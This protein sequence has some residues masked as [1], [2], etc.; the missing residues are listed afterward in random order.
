LT[1]K[2]W[3]TM[4]SCC[5][6]RM[7]LVISTCD[8]CRVRDAVRRKRRD[9]W[10]EQCFLHKDGAPSHTSLAVQQ[11]LAEKNGSPKHRTLLIWLRVTFSY[12]LLWIWAS[13]GHVS[14]LWRTSNGMRRPNTWKIAKD[15]FRWC[16]QQYQDRW[17][18]YIYVCVCVCVCAH[19]QGSYIAGNYISVAIYSTITVQNH[20]SGNFLTALRIHP[21]NN[22]KLESEE[23]GT[24][25]SV[26]KRPSKLCNFLERFWNP[27]N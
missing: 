21:D 27:W 12:S 18:K 10:Q 13:K 19:A 4:S 8:F 6:D 9:K 16:F 24:D 26:E 2:V 23:N 11:F 22:R 15:A 25:G 5:P 7:F 3:F 20:D 17:S 14:Q 1:S